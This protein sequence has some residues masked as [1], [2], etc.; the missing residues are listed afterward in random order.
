[1]L[2][3]TYTETGLSLEHLSDALD[4]W[5]ELRMRLSRQVKR[6][7]RIERCSASFLLPIDLAERALIHEAIEPDLRENLD[8]A[9][10]DAESIEIIMQGVWL[11]SGEVAS[12]GVFLADLSDRI[13]T[14]LMQL[15]QESQAHII[16]LQ[17]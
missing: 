17:G 11:S 15:W 8:W 5:I 3:F 14:K 2:K 1:M 16:A 9:I 7:L 10:A 13:E 4:E 6:Y 12:E